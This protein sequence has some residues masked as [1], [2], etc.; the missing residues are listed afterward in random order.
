MMNL[1][2][3]GGALASISSI[4]F[5]F[6]SCWLPPF[7]QALSDSQLL[8]EKMGD[9]VH[10]SFAYMHPYEAEYGYYLVPR[11]PTLYGDGFWV[12]S[13]NGA[14]YIRAAKQDPLTGDRYFMS[15]GW[16]DYDRLGPAALYAAAVND[17]NTLICFT[18]DHAGLV[19]LSRGPGGELF[20]YDSVSEGLTGLFGAGSVPGGTGPDWFFLIGAEPAV[21]QLYSAGIGGTEAVSPSAPLSLALPALDP[22]TVPAA[23]AFVAIESSSGDVYLSVELTDGTTRTFIWRYGQYAL[24][25]IEADFIDRRISGV[26]SDGRLFSRGRTGLRV[27]DVST[28]KSFSLRLG[29]LRFVHERYEPLDGK[30]RCVFTRAALPQNDS[31][32]EYSRI[33][34][35]VFEVLTE[36]LAEISR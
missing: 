9:P 27:Y 26:L 7:D 24:P 31:R 34:F 3:A 29:S 13:R 15:Y 6:F 30:W 25:P 22:F 33:R 21:F 11:D 5:L 12:Q 23:P 19:R 2:R 10:V 28:E 8:V 32:D 18:N 20:R 4:A 17:P 35:E 14:V 36:E 1:K 16:G